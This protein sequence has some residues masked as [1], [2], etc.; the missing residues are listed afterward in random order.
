MSAWGRLNRGETRVDFVGHRRRWFTLSAIL[1]VA[2][3]ASFGL[4]GLNLGIEF[5]GPAQPLT[6]PGQ[7]RQLMLQHLGAAVEDTDLSYG[8]PTD[9]ELCDLI[10]GAGSGR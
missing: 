9:H 10:D 4:R 6:G 7:V 3:L 2:S 5:E 8:H 1:I